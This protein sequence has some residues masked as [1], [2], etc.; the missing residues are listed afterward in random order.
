MGKY[1]VGYD[2]S[3]NLTEDP[4]AVYG[5][6]KQALLDLEDENSSLWGTNKRKLASKEPHRLSGRSAMK[7]PELWKIC[8]PEG[9]GASFLMLMNL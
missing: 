1:I 5:I 2:E 9:S 3:L 7:W 4:L 8:S 6:E